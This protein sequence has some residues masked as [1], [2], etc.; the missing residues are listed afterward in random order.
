MHEGVHQSLVQTFL[1]E[2]LREVDEDP[3]LLSTSQLH[4]EKSV[5]HLYTVAVN[6][7]IDAK[8]FHFEVDNVQ[9][10]M[11]K[12]CEHGSLA[13]TA[14]KKYSP[15]TLAPFTDII[16]YV[17]FG[18]LLAA[19]GEKPT[20]LNEALPDLSAKSHP[21]R[22]AQNSGLPYMDAVVEFIQHG[23]GLTR[24][25]HEKPMVPNF[26]GLIDYM[27]QGSKF[28][29]L[30][31]T[32]HAHQQSSDFAKVFMGSLLY[33]HIIFPD[34]TDDDLLQAEILKCEPETI[35]RRFLDMS[36]VGPAVVKTLELIEERKQI[37]E[38]PC[39]KADK[40]NAVLHSKPM[41]KIEAGQF[42]SK[43]PHYPALETLD[44][45]SKM[46][47]GA[48]VE[49]EMFQP[50]LERA[51][52]ENMPLFLSL[53]RV[54]ADLNSVI[55]VAAT[56]SKKLFQ[57]KSFIRQNERSGHAEVDHTFGWLAVAAQTALDRVKAQA[58]SESF[59]T[60]AVPDIRAVI[61]R[62]SRVARWFE[63]ALSRFIGVC[64]AD[65]NHKA[66]SI[67]DDVGNNH[68]PPNFL[69]P[70]STEVNLHAATKLFL[71]NPKTSKLANV[72]GQLDHYRAS[73]IRFTSHFGISEAEFAVHK[74]T[75][76]IA[77]ELELAEG[78][79]LTVLSIKSAVLLLTQQVHNPNIADHCAQW[80]L[81]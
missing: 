36:S 18:C 80:E 31:C 23:A 11:R 22:S 5:K 74:R 40:S 20:S 34:Q 13:N 62:I 42:I 58:A 56:Y 14:A 17:K 6:L 4:Q 43:L 45:A 75:K 35:L 78:L 38:R 26:V 46:M 27:A 50:F 21:R 29:G 70:F 15:S 65:G 60:L 3:L 33:E 25:R 59:A 32:V 7:E 9:K 68:V 81:M 47:T 79:G 76:D 16:G 55:M 39:D 1:A 63:I 69:A 73:Y 48:A 19:F 61:T 41:S 64:F 30:L 12:V 37:A 24:A 57:T 72:T 2:V 49:S 44:A 77:K 53:A 54:L 67:A 52:E 66:K 51:T 10:L 71:V 28:F 8:D